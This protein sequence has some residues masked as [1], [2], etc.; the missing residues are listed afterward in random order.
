MHKTIRKV[1][2]RSWS[3]F[4]PVPFIPIQ[5]IFLKQFGFELGNRIKVK[6]EPEKIIITKFNPNLE[7]KIIL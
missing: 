4:Q 6:Y 7:R 3:N 2:Y 1:S 5:G